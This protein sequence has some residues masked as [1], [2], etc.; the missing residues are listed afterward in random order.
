MC[1]VTNIETNQYHRHTEEKT[2]FLYCHTHTK[3]NFFKIVKKLENSSIFKTKKKNY[4]M[5]E[6]E[7]DP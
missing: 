3:I 5:Y 1:T 2:E 4:S 6:T 7:S